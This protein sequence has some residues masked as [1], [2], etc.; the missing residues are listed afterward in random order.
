MG[1][2]YGNGVALAARVFGKRWRV[3]V[4]I[5][6][7]ESQEG[8]VWEAAM[9]TP[10]RRLDNVTLIVDY[11]K[12][13]IDGFVKDVKNLEPFA[14]KWRA[15]GWDVKEVDGH[16]F[17]EVLDAYAWADAHV[18]TGKPACVLAHT[19]KGKGVSFMENK[20]EYHGRALNDDEMKRA[21]AE[22]GEA[23]P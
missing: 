1:L 2:S 20:A 15:F 23:W 17:A 5:G 9:T 4:M 12:I 6:D 10:H 19:V 22:L 7:G 21:M 14:D 18:G 11:N 3:W 8:N 16:D 13:Q